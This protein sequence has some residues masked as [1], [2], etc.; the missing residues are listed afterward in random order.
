MHAF[1][2]SAIEVGRLYEAHCLHLGS[3]GHRSNPRCVKRHLLRVQQS[4][5]SPWHGVTTTP[6]AAKHG[7][8]PA[9]TPWTDSMD[10]V[11]PLIAAKSKSQRMS[12]QTLQRVGTWNWCARIVLPD[13][14]QGESQWGGCLYS[15]LDFEIDMFYA[16]ALMCVCFGNLIKQFCNTTSCYVFPMFCHCLLASSKNLARV[17]VCCLSLALD[18]NDT[19]SKKI[20]HSR[21][22]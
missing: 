20:I 3:G 22:E 13:T 7:T 10:Q 1:Q 18:Q 11:K 8:L 19:I 14:R 6:C 15:A 16:H 4:G 2:N 9:W 21:T 5:P 12:S 17:R